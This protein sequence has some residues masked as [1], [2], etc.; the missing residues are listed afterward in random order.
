MR[1]AFRVVLSIGIAVAVVLVSVALL[2][3]SAPA[4]KG[5]NLTAPLSGSLRDLVVREASSAARF[6]HLSPL[7]AKEVVARISSMSPAQIL[8]GGGMSIAAVQALDSCAGLAGS[9]STLAGVGLGGCVLGGLL[10]APAGGVGAGV[11]CVV[12]AFAT[13]LVYEF[14]ASQSAAQANL[15]AFNNWATANSNA[16]TSEWNILGAQETTLVSA[17]NETEIA[18]QRMAD[19]AALLQL[20]NGSFNLAQDEFQSGLM[21]QFGSLLQPFAASANTVQLNAVN[22]VYAQCVPGAVFAG[23]YATP[24]MTAAPVAGE[25]VQTAN[26]GISIDDTQENVTVYIPPGTTTIYGWN[27]MTS[28]AIHPILGTGWVTVPVS[29]GHDFNYTYSAG[30]YQLGT[31]LSGSAAPLVFIPGGSL[32]T[33][34]TTYDISGWTTAHGQL[35]DWTVPGGTGYMLA[36]TPKMQWFTPLNAL[37]TQT[38]VTPYAIWSNLGSY[39]GSLEYHAAVNGEEYWSFLRA[40]G[41]DS[42]SQ[43]PADCLVPAPY[44]VLPANLNLSSLNESQLE[45]LYLAWLNAEGKFYNS[46]LSGTAFCGT[47]AP[48]QFHL[49]NQT[50]W[51]NLYVNAT[52]YVYLNNGTSPVTAKGT[53][54]PSEAYGNRSTWALAD[55]QLLLMPTLSNISIPVGKNW[56]VPATDPV[57][58]YAIQPALLLTLSGNG[59]ENSPTSLEPLALA[60]GDTVYLSSCTIGGSAQANCTVTVQTINSTVPTILCLGNGTNS[61]AS[62]EPQSSGG[63]FGGFPNPFSWLTGLFS[64]LFG[65]GPLG[66]FLGSIVSGIL[67]LAAIG[68]L[69]YVAIT[70][71]EAWGRRK[72]GGGD[73]TVIARGV[74]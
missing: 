17:L 29:D 62:C 5:L 33:T 59:T 26:T 48:H 16:A 64:S 28:L 25:Y 66:S 42:A 53:K 68:V 12:G 3:V 31:A 38:S 4:S 32:A 54:D 73:S 21:A 36:G 34:S 60:P 39:L 50:I 23:C 2:P 41:F 30:L 44:Q 72:R 69:A 51:G 65:G 55:V 70:E 6:A 40:A 8:E 22:W 56:A 58:V 27:S 74:R 49:G 7:K 37:A 43:I 13:V 9:C 20:G 71:I 15:A 57:Q 14:G 18:F 52:G 61:P 10:G 19:H 45:S 24:T 46:S 1:T 35:S 67:I 47:Q 11:G 63:T